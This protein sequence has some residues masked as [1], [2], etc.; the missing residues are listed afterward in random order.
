[1]RGDSY[2]ARPRAGYGAIAIVVFAVG[3][4]STVDM[5]SALAQSAKY[6]GNYTGTQTLV[7]NE[8]VKNYSKCLGGPF[9]R[10]LI[11]KGG[12]AAFIY[13]PTSSAEVLGTVGADGEVSA[14]ESNPQGGVRLTGQIQGD[15]FTG[16]IWSV[17]CTYSLQLKRTR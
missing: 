8:E 3:L 15:D 11:I 4:S 5:N 2:A 14:A 12:T 7:Q 1:M 17:I 9:K 13:N 6:D 16:K 10:T